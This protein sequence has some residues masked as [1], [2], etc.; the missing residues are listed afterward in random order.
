MK[1]LSAAAVLLMVLAGC[2]SDGDSDPSTSSSAA[3]NVT[4]EDD[5]TQVVDLRETDE[6][7]FVPENPKLTTGKIRIDFTNTSKTNTHSLAF[8]PGGPVEEIPFI[9][10]GEKESIGFSIAT[11]GEY[12]FFCTF[13]ES[14]G[15]RGML[16]VEEP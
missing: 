6:Y 11:P 7:R 1:R 5:G 14:L 8:K 2:S 4:V 12:Q 9:N 16:V 13:H 10:P 15:Q 3:S